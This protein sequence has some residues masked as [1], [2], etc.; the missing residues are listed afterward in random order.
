MFRQAAHGFGHARRVMWGPFPARWGVLGSAFA[1]LFLGIV[2]SLFALHHQ[3]LQ[4]AADPVAMCTV[5]ERAVFARTSIQRVDFAIEKGSKNSTFGVV[6]FTLGG[7][8]T[9]KMMRVTPDEARA[10]TH[11][12]Q[13]D[14]RLDTPIDVDFHEAR[15]FIVVGFVGLI[16]SIVLAIMGLSRMGHF[17]LTVSPDGQTLRVRRSLF[18]FPLGTRELPLSRVAS[19][20]VERKTVKPALA[21][22]NE[23]EVP[24]ARLRLAYRGREDSE[25]LTEIFFPGHALHYRAAF[26]LR[27]ALDAPPDERDDAELAK[28]PMR[29]TPWS[30]RIGFAWAGLTTGSLVGLMLFGLSMFAA[31]R[32]HPRDNLEGWIFLGGMIPGAIGGVALVLHATRTRLPR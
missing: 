4:C 12:I 11:T 23:G 22:R 7:N 24:V 10:A 18:A 19:V 9:Y 30:Q 31:G 28:I 2:F 21:S 20:I 3:H 25:P 27:R 14:L 6:T 32:I 1:A 15:L 16:G 5:N 13:D 26:A 17:D 29:T 8:A